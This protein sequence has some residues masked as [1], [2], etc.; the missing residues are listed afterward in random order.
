MAAKLQKNVGIGGGLCCFSS[1]YYI[2]SSR[3]HGVWVAKDYMMLV[4]VGIL[5]DISKYV[6]N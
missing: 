3:M 2:K 6:T 1:P 4:V 5:D